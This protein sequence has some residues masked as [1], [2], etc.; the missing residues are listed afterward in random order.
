MDNLEEFYDEIKDF[1]HDSFSEYIE[2]DEDGVEII[3]DVI[4]YQK[5]RL[6]KFNTEYPRKVTLNYNVYEVA[7][8]GEVLKNTTHDLVAIDEKVTDRFDYRNY[9]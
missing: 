7:E 9:E 3:E 5:V 1:L 2:R 4:E 6:F 8:K